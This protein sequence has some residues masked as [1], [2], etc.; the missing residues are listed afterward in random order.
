MNSIES[1]IESVT[2]S[3]QIIEV[4]NDLTRRFGIFIDWNQQ[5]I[6]PYL[7]DFLIRYVRYMFFGKMIWLVI[8]LL[9]FLLAII[10]HKRIIK[11]AYDKFDEMPESLATLIIIVV[12]ILSIIGIIDNIF[13][14]IK[15]T[16]IPEMV[17]IDSIKDVIS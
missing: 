3:S 13:G 2:L 10:F 6:I 7:Q 17:I 15:I 12:C 8:S 11:F 16:T 14:M 1:A 5:N 9:C 4:L